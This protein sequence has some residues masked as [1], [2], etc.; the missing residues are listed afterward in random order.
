MKHCTVKCSASTT[1]CVWQMV[2]G[3]F[4]STG[5]PAVVATVGNWFGPGR[6]VQLESCFLGLGFISVLFLSSG[7]R[8]H[9]QK[10]RSSPQKT[11]SQWKVSLL[12][13]PSTPTPQIPRINMCVSLLGGRGV[14]MESL[15]PSCH[16]FD[17][18]QTISPEPLN[19]F[20]ANFGIV[21]YYH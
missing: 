11:Q 10:L 21:V 4:Q 15:H 6:L 13:P 16:V 14:V 7:R 1:F 18:V 17:F 5:W 9:V 8:L 2:A 19:H 12:I 20:Q 3:A